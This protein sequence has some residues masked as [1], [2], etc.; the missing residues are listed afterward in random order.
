LV[1]LRVPRLEP[2]LWQ[3]VLQNDRSVRFPANVVV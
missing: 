3:A 2:V 1:H